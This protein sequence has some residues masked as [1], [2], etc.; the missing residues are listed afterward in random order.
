MAVSVRVFVR[1]RL[2]G[3]ELRQA[4]R[5]ER[6]KQQRL[7][8]AGTVEADAGETQSCFG[9]EMTSEERASDYCFVEGLSNC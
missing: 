1:S 7:L 4:A 5:A 9:F 3:F 2:E 8:R 6:R